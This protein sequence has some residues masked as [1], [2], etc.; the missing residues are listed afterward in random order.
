VLAEAVIAEFSPPEQRGRYVGI[1][2]TLVGTTFVI[3]PAVL[4]LLVLL[5]IY[6]LTTL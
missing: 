3:G 4:V 5:L 1:F 2:E 6:A